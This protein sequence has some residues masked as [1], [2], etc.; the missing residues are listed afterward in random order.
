MSREGATARSVA[1]TVPTDV[2]DVEQRTIPLTALMSS[3][4]PEQALQ[5]KSLIE[6][7]LN[8][9]Q[10]ETGELLTRHRVQ[11]DRLAH[12]EQSVNEL[13][14]SVTQLL[15]TH[16]GYSTNLQDEVRQL[17][18]DVNKLIVANGRTANTVLLAA[19][20]ERLSVLEQRARTRTTAQQ[21]AHTDQ[22]V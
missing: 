21:S 5:V 22:P 20:N 16:Q 15:T 18:L 4:T 1:P 10:G 9:M 8:P 11:A 7:S 13:T 19:I 2:S 6:N 17:R 3:F 12:T 14:E